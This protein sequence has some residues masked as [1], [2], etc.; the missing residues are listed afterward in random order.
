MEN[1]E[2]LEFKTNKE[3]VERVDEIVEEVEN[4][5]KKSVAIIGRTYDE[6]KKIKEY[7]K[8]IVIINGI[9]LKDTDKN[10]KLEKI[11]I[12]S[13]M[14]KGLEFDC[15]VIYN[16]NKENY[17]NNELDKKILY[18]ALQEHYI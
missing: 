7:L 11:I 10:L 8:N 18:V 15:S 17:T 6:C 13:Y 1:P 16:C 9:L 4:I 5:N 3:F 12:P 2:I 14:T